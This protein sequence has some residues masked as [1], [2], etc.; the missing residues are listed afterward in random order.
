ML[1]RLAAAPVVLVM[2]AGAAAPAAAQPAFAPVV[3]RDGVLAV[4]GILPEASAAT[5]PFAAQADGVLA[6][7]A[8]RLQAAG[9]SLPNVVSTTVYLADAA[10]FPALNDAW[11]QAWPTDPP[12]RTTVVATLP[13]AGVRLQVSAIAVPNGAE[14]VVV[15]PSTWPA[16]TSPYSWAIRSGD[17]LY[18]SGLI[19]RRGIDNSIVAG[20]IA[21]QTRAVLENAKDILGA[22]GL[23]FGDVVTSRVFVT[24]VAEFQAM[25]EAYRPF[26][27]GAPPPARATVRCGLTHPDYRV[28]ITLTAVRGSQ[29]QAL[30]TPA[31]TGA[32]GQPN[33]NLSSAI[34][35]G[36]HL[37]LSGMLGV[38]A[39][40]GLDLSAQTDE[41]LNRLERTMTAAGMTWSNVYDSVIY[42]TDASQ[43]ETA[44]RR[45]RARMG[46]TPVAGT[47]VGTG[48]VVPDGV[49]EIMITAAKQE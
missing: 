22:A 9:S 23:S 34:H 35:V 13:V 28:E 33:P 31:A 24:N 11:R 36:R 38:V 32:P 41:T 5:S 46:R 26:F 19:P 3:A 2:L 4:S 30:T 16:P 10:D 43:G 18:L 42:V 29:R 12:T 49:V 44:A 40:A 14:R 39:G 47:V 7:L 20:D 27:A 45:L 25:N 8:S 37:F 1:P 6:T 48:L 15:K 17:T 21:T